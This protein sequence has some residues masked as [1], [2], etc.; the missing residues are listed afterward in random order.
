MSLKK[1]TFGKV[2]KALT[3]GAGACTVA[4]IAPL[5][6]VAVVAITAVA[7]GTSYATDSAG[8]AITAAR[9]K[10]KRK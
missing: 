10:K 8:E 4:V 1:I 5:G 7:A 2:A 3:V 6:I 9:T